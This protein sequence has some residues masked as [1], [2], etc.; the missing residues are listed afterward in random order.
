V[1]ITGTNFVDGAV[2]L[3]NGAERPTKFISKTQLKATISGS[4]QLDPAYNSL[5]VTNP[6]PGGGDS[7]VMTF[8]V[9]PLVQL[10]IP[11]VIR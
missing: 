9:R 7:N 8:I 11:M 1:T 4:D 3:W 6:K 5:M 2:V 10:F